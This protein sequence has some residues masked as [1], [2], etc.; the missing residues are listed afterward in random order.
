M[1]RNVM[2]YTILLAVIFLL[3]EYEV[4]QGS[5]Q[6]SVPTKKQTFQPNFESLEKANPVPE[7]FRDA[8]FGIY[9]HWGV[10]SVPAFANEWYPRSMYIK[11]SAENK[12][13]LANYGEVSEWPYHNFIIGAKDKQGRFVQFAPKLKSEGGQF[14]PDEWAQLFA[15]AGAK[16]AGPV[17]EHHDGFSMWAS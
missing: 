9:F 2:K 1:I 8:K 7:W 11:G 5:Q 14:D 15:D 17:A 16:F 13:H 10:Y 6:K 12:H 3:Q 4:A